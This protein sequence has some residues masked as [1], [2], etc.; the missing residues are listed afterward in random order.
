MQIKYLLLILLFCSACGNTSQPA[1]QVK[2]PTPENEDDV[3]L[4]LSSELVS[5]AITQADKDKNAIL[6]YAM[7]KMVDVQSTSSGIYYQIIEKGEGTLAK[8]GDYVTTHYKGYTLEGKVFDSSYARNKPLQFYIGNMI[9]G[10]NE[11]LELLKPGGKAIFMIPSALAYGEKGL[12]K[13][14]APNTPLVFEVHLLK[15]EQ[16]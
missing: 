4:R 9:A 12:G 7:D 6:N 5:P 3:L 14:I 8:W 1:E 15:V 11:G 10:W 13:N 16:K 2:A